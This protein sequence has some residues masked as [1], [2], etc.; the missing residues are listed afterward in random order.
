MNSQY[1]SENEIAVVM[2]VHNTQVKYLQEALES[3]KKQ[4]FQKFRLICVDDKST[5]RDTIQV[6]HEWS[7][8]YKKME[9][10][11][12]PEAMGAAEA[13]N[14]GL[15]VAKEKYIIFLDSDDI[16]EKDFLQ[17]MY[18][19]ITDTDAQ[20]CIC[21]W[22]S[23]STIGNT[24][25]VRKVYF[26]TEKD[27]PF[28]LSN[29]AFNPWSKLCRRDFLLQRN[30]YFQNLTSSNDVYYSI[31]V[32]L[33]AEQIC[34]IEDSL[35]RY[36][37]ASSHQISANRNSDNLGYACKLAMQ[38]YEGKANSLKRIQ[39]FTAMLSAMRGE[40]KNNS[41]FERLSE[42]IRKNVI[43]DIDCE[44]IENKTI[45]K[46]FLL[47]KEKKYN[48]DAMKKELS[49]KSQIYNN[50]DEI[51]DRLKSNSH[52]YLWGLGERGKAFQEFCQENDIC[53]SGVADSKNVNVGETNEY[54]NLIMDTSEILKRKGIII[55]C[56]D[57][58]YKKFIHCEES[59]KIMNLQE[60]CPI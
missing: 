51:L 7:E 6:L 15:H 8:E 47:I 16:F 4:T 28:F 58:V 44:N 59:N 49:F 25:T 18:E 43:K 36:R 10:I 29:Q 35:I 19:R 57:I 48:M 20:V 46:V 21:G 11:Y 40:C 26:D 38:R 34:C 22:T 39:I 55:A 2:P 13:R 32:L 37:T 30:I 53:I 33:E 42:Y 17:K 9:V 24:E 56:N 12:L 23:F 3:L 54:G 45:K 52:I 5:A 41:S 1:A 27:N 14:I 31:C 60:Y 50:K